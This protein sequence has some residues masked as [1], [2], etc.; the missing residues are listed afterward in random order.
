M[1]KFWILVK[2]SCRSAATMSA[3]I[4]EGLGK[5]PRAFT[6]E[7]KRATPS[8]LQILRSMIH[9]QDRL[10]HSAILQM[11]DSG[12]ADNTKLRQSGGWE[13]ATSRQ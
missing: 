6:P 2:S 7:G 11:A 5:L 9:P 4:E 3:Y 12:G 8:D 13:W 10:C 1:W